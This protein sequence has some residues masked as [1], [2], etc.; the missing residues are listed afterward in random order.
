MSD[1]RRGVQFVIGF[2]AGALA[3]ATIS[4]LFDGLAIVLNRTLGFPF[5]PGGWVGAICFAAL[6]GL[7]WGA[8]LMS[9][10]FGD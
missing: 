3:G 7:S 8:A 9:G 5:K 4:L 6:V 10:L 2:V 1:R